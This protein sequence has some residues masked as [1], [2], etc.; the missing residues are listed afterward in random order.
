MG[1]WI[2]AALMTLL[3]LA[4]VAVPLTRAPRRS[5]SALDHDR[6]LYRARLAEIDA[7][8]ELG[9]IGAEE[10]AAARAEEGR[11]LIALSAGSPAAGGASP[12]MART[13]LLASLVF[14]PIATLLFYVSSGVPN[15]PDMAIAS[16]PDRDPSQ[17]TIQQLLERAEAQLAR[18]PDDARGW[19]VVAPVY[20]R[21]GRAADAVTAYRNALR[22][23]P[24]SID[25]R[26]SLAEAI[27]VAAEGVVTEEARRLFDEALERQPGNAK[28]RFYLAIALGQQGDRAEAATAWR[29]LIADAPADAQWLPVARAQ[30]AAVEGADRPA[31]AETPGPTAEDIEAAG[32][33]SAVD[34]Q[35]MIEAMV[36][37]LAE[38]LKDNPDDKDGW[39]RLVRSYSVLGRPE[40]AAEAVADARG[41]FADDGEFLAE[42][43]AMLKEGAATGVTR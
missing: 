22:L 12:A 8:L 21:M 43:E 7:E 18:N 19:A 11:K 38:K 16:R 27:T 3:A 9:R 14:V 30:L 26:T 31:E 35:A 6:A 28:A 1:F 39:R 37:G 23:S 25:L 4:F 20:L 10:A 32:Q 40:A 36:A 42:L 29:A 33:L 13:A 17:Q 15:M 41:H 5:A 34:R 2:A 24:D